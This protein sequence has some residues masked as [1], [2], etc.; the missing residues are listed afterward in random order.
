MLVHSSA[1]CC[2]ARCAGTAAAKTGSKCFST[3]CSSRRKVPSD[4]KG[5]SGSS[6]L[7]LARQL[8]DPYVEKAKML[9]YRCRS[10]FKLLEIDDRFHLL[11]PGRC[12]VDCGAAPGSWT[13]VLVQRTN[14]CGRDTRQAV[15]SV[16]AVDRQ[17]IHP[18]EGATIIGNMDFTVP[19]TRE[20]VREALNGRGA[21]GV[22]SDM[23]PNASGVRE[24]DHEN[25]THLAYTALRFAAQA[26][27][28]GAFFLVKMW[29][30]CNTRSL[31]RDLAAFY[32]RVRTVKPGASR[33]DS[34]ETFLLAQ[35]FKGLK[36]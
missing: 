7:W 35:D 6:Q 31:A 9:N 27:G 29:D 34:A 33:S 4:L 19:E 14:A 13:Q 3:C 17:P 15:G 10:A 26:S 5:R 25:I 11:A 23:A 1:Q 20:R 16:V 12:V 22:V 2:F 30:G 18:I 21:D 32:A 24:M 8:T 36:N 28:S